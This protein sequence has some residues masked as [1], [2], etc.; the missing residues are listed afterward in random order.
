MHE[1]EVF[2][3][4]IPLSLPSECFL[5]QLLRRQ[6]QNFGAHFLAGFEFHQGGRD[7][8]VGFRLV[9]DCGRRAPCGF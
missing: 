5:S 2:I 9:R 6:L 7:G 8:H 4:R 1:N 3:S